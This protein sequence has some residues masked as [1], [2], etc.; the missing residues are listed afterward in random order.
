MAGGTDK[1][2]EQP[3]RRKL[4]KAREK[5]QVARSRE[6]PAAA[7]LLG[8]V[9]MLYYFGQDFFHFPLYPIRTIGALHFSQYSPSNM[10]F[11]FWGRG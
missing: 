10:T 11:P 8:V 2:T 9:L 3:T 5:G 1:K 7:V 4:K 6:V